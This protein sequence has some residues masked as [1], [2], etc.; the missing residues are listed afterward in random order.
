MRQ[1]LDVLLVQSNRGAADEAVAALAAAGHRVHQC[2]EDDDRGF[3]CRG[4]LASSACP[5]DRPIDV[6]LSV[7]RRLNPWPT[8]LEGGVVCAIRA[9]LPVVEQTADETGPFTPWVTHRITPKDD[10]V[11]A[12]VQAAAM[13]EQG[14]AADIRLRIARVLEATEVDPSTVTCWTEGDDTGLDVHVGVSGPLPHGVSEA[15]AVRALDAIRSSSRTYG[16]VDV[17]V[18]DLSS[19]G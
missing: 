6:V 3:P 2:Y 18:H 19:A 17:H 8:G 14:L 4:V 16:R 5:L 11:D 7:R 15:V 12:C 9:G 13:V 10:V 1:Q